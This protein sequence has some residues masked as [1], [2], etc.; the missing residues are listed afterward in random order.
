[1]NIQIV[2][3]ARNREGGVNY[4]NVFTMPLP[5]EIDADNERKN[6]RILNVTYPQT[7]ENV[8]EKECGIRIKYNLSRTIQ[9]FPASLKYQTP[10]IYLPA[11]HYSLNKM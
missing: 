4:N 9:G 1:M 3:N 2:S 10:L 7:I 5:E 11:G 6:I 8:H